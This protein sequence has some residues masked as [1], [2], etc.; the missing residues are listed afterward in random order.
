[1]IASAHSLRRVVQTIPSALGTTGVPHGRTNTAPLSA[2][3]LSAGLLL[4]AW[5]EGRVDPALACLTAAIEE[6]WWSF[7]R[8]HLPPAVAPERATLPARIRHVQ[9][10]REQR[11]VRRGVRG[12]RCRVPHSQSTRSSSRLAGRARQARRLRPGQPAGSA[13][14]CR[15]VAVRASWAA[16]R[17]WPSS[18]FRPRRRFPGRCAS[19]LAWERGVPPA[20]GSDLP[21]IGTSLNSPGRTSLRAERISSVCRRTY[22]HAVDSSTTIANRLPVRF[23]W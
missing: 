13:R 14:W 20:Q 21:R 23:C 5:Q 22:G 12:L 15:R 19:R 3:S 6:P 16:A 11:A 4:R 17:R 10:R 9:R 2:A 7:W 18:R 8:P 1:M